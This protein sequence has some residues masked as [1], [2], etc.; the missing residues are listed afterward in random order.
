MNNSQTALK[1]RDQLGRFLGIFSPHFS[2]P[3]TDFIGEM[4][5]GIQAAR[6]IK[7]S[8]IGRSLEEAI[9]LKKTEERLCRNLKNPDIGKVVSGC[10]AKESAQ[11]IRKDTLIII[12]PTDIQKLYAKKMLFLGK[13]WDGSQSKVGSNLGY[14]CCLAIAC[15]SGGRRV[16]PL[17]LRLWS[18]NAPEYKSINEEIYQTVETVRKGAGNRGIYVFDRG[19]DGMNIYNMFLDSRL[20][21]IVRMVGN[22]NLIWNKKPRLA[23]Q[24]ADK[25]KMLYIDTIRHEM[26]NGEK[27]YKLQYGC[28]NVTLPERPEVSLRMIVVKGLGSRPMLLLTTLAETSSRKALWQVV[29]GYLSRWRV[30]DSIRWIKQSYR[31]EDI[32]L[33]NYTRLQNMVTLLLAAAYFASTW[34][35]ANLRRSIL[36]QNITCVSKRLFGVAEFHYYAIADGLAR[37][38][39]RHGKWQGTTQIYTYGQSPQLIL[40]LSFDSA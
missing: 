27:I 37:L 36:V 19:G 35:G 40:P 11:H 5:Y 38:F 39:N 15:S 18:C 7:L 23:E 33:M 25:C 20:R 34:I 32:R 30:E 22:R 1:V 28:I 6:D 29:E 24:L 12:D 8:C 26:P 10:V 2:K 17:H 14:N 4:L 16:V 9:S 3:A 13:V 21:F 31:L